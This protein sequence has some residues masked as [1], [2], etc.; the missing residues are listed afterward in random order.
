MRTI[1]G[2][3]RVVGVILLAVVVLAAT[4]LGYTITRSFPQTTGSARLPGLSASVE[5][6]RDA[7]GVPHI[8][9]DTPHDLFMAQGFIH[10]QD[11]FW[12]MDFWRHTTAG[13]L[14]EL[15]GESQVE[16]D[17][18]LRT[19]GWRRV[20]EQ[21]YAS[22]DAEMRGVLD[23]YA[24]GVNAYIGARSYAD[25]GLEYSLL[26]LNG[27]D[28]GQK[29]YAW[30]GADS[31]AWA[32]A[33]AWDLGGNMD[34]EI[35]RAQ[36][37][38]ALGAEKA[39]EFLVDPPVDHPLIM[40]SAAFDG[41]QL[42]TIRAQVNGVRALFGNGFGEERR[43]LGSNNWVIGGERTESGQPLLA[44]DPHLSIQLPAIWYLIG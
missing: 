36:L 33:M 25:L 26:A 7:N 27:F 21:E 41:L 4:F 19:V 23:A 31:L 13:R 42:D 28:P 18:F 37:T 40:P 1:L 9:A 3:L 44:N 10:A 20:A 17:M 24:A 2:V 8:Y 14:S 22:A 32:K 39:R 12:Q 34:D 35:Y 5:V 6:I 30:T 11:R 38:Q 16:T 15:V 43:G 29:P